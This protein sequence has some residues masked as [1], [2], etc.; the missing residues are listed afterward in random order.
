MFGN[1]F[2]FATLGFKEEKRTARKGHYSCEFCRARKLRCS[3]PLPCINCVSRGKRCVVEE[4]GQMEVAPTAYRREHPRPPDAPLLPGNDDNNQN[5]L[6][7]EVHRL[8]RLA[9]DL[10]R[11]IC[12]SQ[13]TGANRGNDEASHCQALT[14][15][16]AATTTTTATT[17]TT[18]TPTPGGATPVPLGPICAVVT[19][20]DRVSMGNGSYADMLSASTTGS[21]SVLSAAPTTTTA[22]T[23]TGGGPVGHSPD[24]KRGLDIKIEHVF[25][26]PTAP[27]FTYSLVDGDRLRAPRRCIYLPTYREA[28]VLLDTFL[29]TVSSLYH[30]VHHPTMPDTVRS[31]Y[32]CIQ[33]QQAG[34]SPPPLGDVL[35]LLSIVATGACLYIPPRNHDNDDND[36]D[37]I[38]ASN[39]SPVFSSRA[40]AAQTTP[41][42]IQ[43]ALHVFEAIVRGP[44]PPT[45]SAVQG[46]IMLSFLIGNIEGIGFRYRYLVST[47]LLLGREL[48]LHCIDQEAAPSF[49]RPLFDPPKSPFEREMGRRVWWYLASTEWLLAAR[50]S[51]PGVGVYSTHPNMMRVN[52]PCNTDDVHLAPGMRELAVSQPLDTPTDMSY[53][54]QRVRLAEVTRGIVDRMCMVSGT[55]FVGGG[56]SAVT[57]TASAAS[58]ASTMSQDLLAA[59]RQAA[60]A[61]DADLEAMLQDL[62][63]FLRLETYVQRDSTHAGGHTPIVFIQ[64]FM[65]HSLIHTQ[66]CKLHLPYLTS[67]RRQTEATTAG[68]AS[69]SSQPSD[70]LSEE[71]TST[72]SPSSRAICIESARQII[73]AETQLRR[74]A[75]QHPMVQNRLSCVLYGVFMAAIVLLVDLC[76][77][78][79]NDEA[80]QKQDALAALQ[81]VGD[82][83]PHSPAAVELYASLAHLL[84]KHRPQLCERGFLQGM[85]AVPS[86][87]GTTRPTETTEPVLPLVDGL[88]QPNSLGEQ[89]TPMT[90]LGDALYCG[91]SLPLGLAFDGLDDLASF[92]WDDL[93]AGVDTSMLL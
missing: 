71:P 61:S 27:E 12:Q 77:A 73:H 44:A 53:Y 50:N 36:D 55:Q 67:W 4:G 25:A 85:D 13:G 38:S 6:V 18:T 17:A 32:A 21:P 9:E 90:A 2:Y 75:S 54:L 14:T 66:R 40:A 47:G 28:T 52:E 64:A 72:P 76:A 57:V 87:N 92:Q 5:N 19:H 69:T 62:P 68:H 60:A 26:I 7:D 31:I 89:D 91:N 45:L 16:T 49:S 65:L 80:A 58:A 63:V 8:R 46:V 33:G 34:A 11:R 22:A 83:R 79:D 42:W 74:R 78:D 59:Y 20:L 81:I 70:A 39:A 82:S 24:G 48:S 10:E 30:I 84:A 56:P 37:S 41:L 43:A 1:L 86:A 23:S 35:L 93:L 3:R 29:A 51:G 15:T 88:S